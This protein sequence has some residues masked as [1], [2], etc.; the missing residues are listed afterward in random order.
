MVTVENQEI[1]GGLHRVQFT[2]ENDKLFAYHI[3]ETG[4]SLIL[5]DTGMKDTPQEH[6]APYLESI[7]YGLEDISLAI[8]TH[9]D[10]DHNGGNAELREAN[11]EVIIAA[12]K[13]D[14]PLIESE[15]TI[16]EERYGQ[17]EDLGVEYPGEVKD[18]LRD[19][20]EMDNNVDFR[21]KGG[22]EIKW[23]NGVVRIMHAPGHSAG[24]IIAYDEE[25]DFLIGGDAVYAEGTI[26]LSDTQL[27]P[28]PYENLKDYRETIEK[29]KDLDP[30]LLLMS[31]FLPF[32]GEEVMDWVNQAWQWTEEFQEV[33]EEI[34]RDAEEPLSVE[35][36]IEE[37]VEREG[38]VGMDLDL[39]FPITSHLEEMGLEPEKGEDDIPR[40]SL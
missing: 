22:E 28:P 13:E 5:F 10:A 15:E 21:L 14:V 36:I 30:E 31:H 8:M 37:Y 11:P 34:L 12:H 27:Q 16:M 7:G 29:I 6:I 4:K 18:I 32:E 17:F 1:M 24:S 23:K 3:L 20:M 38:S 33:L 39:A 26:T 35:K 9:A 25:N 40:Y 19:M 2:D